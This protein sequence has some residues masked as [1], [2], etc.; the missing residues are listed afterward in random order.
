MLYPSTFWGFPSSEMDVEVDDSTEE[1]REDSGKT[2]EV[3]GLFMKKRGKSV[4]VP[5]RPST[6]SIS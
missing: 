5:V 4:T 3:T 2:E 1:G 6:P